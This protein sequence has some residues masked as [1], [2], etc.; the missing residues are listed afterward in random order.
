M[1]G[2]AYVVKTLKGSQFSQYGLIMTAVK[3]G[4]LRGGEELDQ[5]LRACRPERAQMF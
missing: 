3:T 1:H 4:R 5:L 2:V